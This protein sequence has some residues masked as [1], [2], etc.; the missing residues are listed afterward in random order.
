MSDTEQPEVPWWLRGF[1]LDLRSLALFRIAVGFCLLVTLL[2]RLPQIG[3]F[4]TDTGILPREALVRLLGPALSLHLVT[5]SW[6]GQLAI[7]LVAIGFAL[8]LIA[9][10]HTR[11]AT[12]A[13]WALLFSMLARNPLV[14]H[15]GEHVMQ[16]MLFWGM[17]LPLNA[18]WSLDA[19]AGRPL[20]NP[21]LSP[22]GVAFILQLGALYWFAVAEKMHPAWTVQGSAI[23]Y[24][25]HTDPLATPLGVA[26]RDHLSFT[27]LLTVGTLTL[28]FLGPFLAIAAVA[29]FPL[30]LVAV[31][32]FVGF[33]VGL[34]ATIR[35]GSF[36]WICAAA[37]LA[38]LPP[39]VW[40][41]SPGRATD[42]WL[43]RIS[44]LPRLSGRPPRPAGVLS[45]LL[46]SGSLI[47][48]TMGLLSP[49]PRLSRQ[50]SHPAQR[51]LDQAGL[52]QRWEMF[53]PHPSLESGWFVM[54]GMTR[55]GQRVDVWGQGTDERRPT[56][57]GKAYRNQQWMGY[58]FL[59]RVPQLAG[60]RP[61]FARYLC[62]EWNRRNGDALD[63]LSIAFVGAQT[64]SP[65]EPAVPPVKREIHRQ[66]CGYLGR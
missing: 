65:G 64:P 39:G 52:L 16:I 5:G 34:A 11:L 50:G 43:T 66:A 51:F 14:A 41:R 30:R 36:P 19:A 58:V 42:A 31:V 13:S 35:L 53:A 29:V 45:H 33:H 2:V 28:E 22:A 47:L 56:D 57:F 6:L 44:A 7:F 1:A 17:F 8:A 12:V 20:P 25:L 55:S 21:Y 48:V 10:Y 3:A 38:L 4:Y 61:Y 27:R 26:L 32:A 18:R 46:V 54:Q 15:A 9:G 40:D 24:A 60:Y 59:L 63:S 37:W 23:Y 62:R 49:P